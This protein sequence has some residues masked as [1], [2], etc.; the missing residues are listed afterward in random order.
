MT[1]KRKRGGPP[2][3]LIDEAPRR[4]KV[5]ESGGEAARQLKTRV[6]T[7]KGRKLSSTR[8]LERQLNDPYVAKAKAAGYRSRAAF[9]LLELDEACRLLRPGMRVVDL[10]CA[11]GGW[12]QAAAKAAAAP[13][14]GRVVG[15]DLQ[16]VEPVAGAMIFEMDFMSPEAPRIL[17]DA[18]GGSADLVMS[19]MAASS[20]GHRQTDHLKIMA[21][22]E[23]ALDFAESVLTPGGAF[24]CKML[25]GGAERGIL[26]RLKQSFANVRHI[27]P[28][29]SRQ[30]SAEIYLVAK[31]F[32]G[33]AGSAD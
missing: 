5:S 7:A 1:R 14:R 18:I 29:A 24:V 4:L 12:L 2:P 16:A 6:K 9:K 10:G 11:P 31:G 19:D 30:D 25:R 20:T 23:A 21:L 3:G 28:A 33:R 15:I 26:D 13:E 8:W 32:R 27:K 17:S 22:A